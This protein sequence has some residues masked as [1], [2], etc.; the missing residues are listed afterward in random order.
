MAQKEVQRVIEVIY[1]GESIAE[2]ARYVHE[3]VVRYCEYCG[4]E[5][6]RS[7]VNDYGELCEDCYQKEYL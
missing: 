4:R 7:D 5:M 6:S 1:S 3:E 2:V